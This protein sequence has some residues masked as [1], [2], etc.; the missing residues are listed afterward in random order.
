MHPAAS[1]SGVYQI[2]DPKW[3]EAR[4]L[5]GRTSPKGISQPRQGKPRPK[6]LR[7][8]VPREVATTEVDTKVLR[9]RLRQLGGI[10]AVDAEIAEQARLERYPFLGLAQRRRNEPD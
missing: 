10:I 3:R 4:S 7:S 5:L 6:T 9:E 2:Y 1:P 8:E